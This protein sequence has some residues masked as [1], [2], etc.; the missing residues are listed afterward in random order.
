MYDAM[1]APGPLLERVNTAGSFASVAHNDG[2]GALLRKRY[3]RD[4]LCLKIFPK[5]KGTMPDELQ[6]G[7]V[8]VYECSRVQNLF[9][10][11]NL[12][13]MVV[14]LVVVNG[15]HLAQVT[16]WA[17]GEGAPDFP[18]LR[19]LI[20]T[21]NIRCTKQ[22]KDR[23]EFDI[24]CDAN[25]RGRWMVDWCGCYFGDPHGYEAY[26]LDRLDGAGHHFTELCTET[27]GARVLRARME[28][29]NWL[30]HWQLLRRL[31]ELC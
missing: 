31:E 12:A 16:E 18:V 7:G 13:P 29:A 6:W 25:W 4:G 3:G 26:L 9:A 19:S 11:H 10:L 28:L 23:D 14:D 30:G 24:D 2:L 22:T 20:H 5:L 17:D 1:K 15:M 8:T 27:A 21:H